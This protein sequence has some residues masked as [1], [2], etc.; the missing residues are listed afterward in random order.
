M[1]SDLLAICHPNFAYFTSTFSSAQI[2]AMALI[3][4]AD[5]K[6]RVNNPVLYVNMVLYTCAFVFMFACLCVCALNAQERMRNLGAYDKVFRSKRKDISCHGDAACQPAW[7]RHKLSM[8]SVSV[9][10]E[11]IA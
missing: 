1:S 8:R 2:V 10:S 7:Y 9:Y 3:R 5:P 6:F 11:K 4:F